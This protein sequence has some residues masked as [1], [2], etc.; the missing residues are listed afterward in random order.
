M[1]DSYD[2]VV[3]GGGIAG[4]A[5]ATRLARDGVR[6]LVLER[7]TEYVDRV[8][9]EAMMPWGVVE[10]KRLGLYDTLIEAGGIHS[11]RWVQFWEGR[12]A[13]EAEASPI[14]VGQVLPDAAPLNIGHPTACAALNNAAVAAGAEVVRGASD[15]KMIEDPRG[16]SYVAGKVARTVSAR[17]VVGADGR[18]SIVREQ[19]GITLDRQDPP[20]MVTGLLIEPETSL[21]DYDIIAAEGDFAMLS[22]L[23]PGG[24]ARV[25]A[26]PPPDQRDRFTGREGGSKLLETLRLD[27]LPMADALANGRA[28]GPCATYPGDESWTARPFSDGVVL[29]GDAAGYNNPIIGQGLSLAMR[30]VRLVSDILLSTP[31]WTT[32]MLRPYGEERLERMRRV[33][34]SA[35]LLAATL[36]QITSPE[37]RFEAQVRRMS[38]PVTFQG[39]LTAF[40]G[41]EAAPPEAFSDEAF[42]N[43]V[44]VTS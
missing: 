17:M 18:T 40:T 30:D 21:P 8:R 29:I 7:T 42:R 11:D 39:L 23:Q 19:A 2:V 43:V 32:E 26:L 36:V 10:L 22:F 28:V 34:F 31:E 33:R 9:G 35:N 37:G 16:V 14:P 3:V 38:D 15:I 20:N 6:V 25:Y 5:L 4:S 13:D 44:A 24:R 27:C 1:S 12:P 41:P